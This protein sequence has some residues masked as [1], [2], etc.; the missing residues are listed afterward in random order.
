MGIPTP[1]A[2]HRKTFDMY[3]VVNRLI[4]LNVAYSV[5]QVD[6]PCNLTKYFELQGKGTLRTFHKVK[7]L[8][9]EKWCKSHDFLDIASSCDRWLSNFLLDG[10]M[11]QKIPCSDK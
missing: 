5:L 4:I 8:P 6:R 7:K 11:H 1:H 3:E 10:F 2:E 9:C